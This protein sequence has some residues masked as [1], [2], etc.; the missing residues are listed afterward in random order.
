MRFVKTIVIALAACSSALP[1]A[2]SADS[3]P[4][5]FKSDAASSPDGKAYSIQPQTGS[6]V[7]VPRDT[8]TTI[9]VVRPQR[10]IVRDV[11]EALPLILSATALLLVLAGIGFTLI[12]TRTVP[13]EAVV[14]DLVERGRDRIPQSAPPADK[15]PD[16]SSQAL[17]PFGVPAVAGCGR[18][19]QPLRPTERGHGVSPTPSRGAR[20]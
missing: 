12:R 15:P 18:V 13:G 7:P 19:E 10:T 20:P 4:P 17:A 9:E 2:A 1:T 5:T 16:S 14:A 8:P 6:R 11:D 3:L